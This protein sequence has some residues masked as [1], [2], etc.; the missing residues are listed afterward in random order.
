MTLPLHHEALGLLEIDSIPRAARAQDAALK[1]AP[2][3]ILACAPVCPGKV[4]LAF[5]GDV[6][7]VEESLNA[8]SR[9]IA[10]SVLDH[11]F[12]PGIHPDVLLAMTGKRQAQVLPAL[13][14]LEL[15]SVAAAIVAADVAVKAS[16]VVIGRLHLATGFGGKAYLTLKGKHCDVEAAVAAV[17]NSATLHLRDVEI[18]AAPHED[19]ETML[20][21][22]PWSYDPGDVP[23]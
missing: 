2:V 20:F 7:S 4:I 5:V 6:A 15:S 22:R 14:L 17:E 16:E 21:V 11:L 13:A 10:S 3:A 19:L 9:I 12:L 1:Q 18:I 8:A 23:P